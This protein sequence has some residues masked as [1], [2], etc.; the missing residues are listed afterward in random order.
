MV[1]PHHVG[2]RLMLMVT[3]LSVFP[4]RRVSASG[5]NLEPNEGESAALVF[6][7]S[8]AAATALSNLVFAPRIV[9]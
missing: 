3:C 5:T 2:I 7:L 8:K 6:D 9:S 1:I 4:C